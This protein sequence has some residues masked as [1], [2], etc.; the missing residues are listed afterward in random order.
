M[1][2]LDDLHGLHA[3]AV[4]LDGQRGLK[5]GVPIG[6][7]DDGEE[8]VLPEDGVRFLDRDI[9]PFDLGADLTP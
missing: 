2:R 5:G 3:E 4:A 6:G 8:V 9:E 7:R 1:I